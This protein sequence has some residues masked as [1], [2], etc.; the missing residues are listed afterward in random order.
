MVDLFAGTMVTVTITTDAGRAVWHVAPEEASFEDLVLADQR[1]VFS[2]DPLR[3][4][5]LVDPHWDMGGPSPGGW[6]F[7]AI[8]T[9]WQPGDCPR[10]LGDST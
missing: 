4:Y 1:K 5:L 6:E 7:D 2:G 3:P 10:R 9:H 8:R